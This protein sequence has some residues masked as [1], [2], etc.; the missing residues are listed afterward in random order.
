MGDD[1]I[2]TTLGHPLW[3]VGKGWRMA[4]NLR[5]GDRLHGVTGAA[6]IN[7]ITQAAE[8]QAFNLVV[9][10]FDT[11]FVGQDGLLAHDSTLR[12]PTA[13]LVPGMRVE[14]LASGRV[15]APDY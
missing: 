4:K 1:E 10:D 11:Y 7:S 2:V 8:D 9:A 3:V 5:T 6:P 13:A 15:S 12:R 14:Q